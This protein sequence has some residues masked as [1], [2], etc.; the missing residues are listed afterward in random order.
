MAGEVLAAT[1]DGV[2]V[3]TLSQPGRRNALT[4]AMRGAVSASIQRISAG[5]TKCHVGRSTCVRSISPALNEASSEASV[6]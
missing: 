3:L 2:L 5:V 4:D 6:A 1:E